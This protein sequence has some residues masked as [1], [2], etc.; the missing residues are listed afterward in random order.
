MWAT[1]SKRIPAILVLLILVSLPGAQAP[2]AETDPPQS[3]PATPA[4][5]V[6]GPGDQI[7]IRALDLEEI[8]DKPFRIGANGTI[9][10]PLLGRVQAAGLTVQELEGQIT[11]SLKPYVRH[12]DVT[13]AVAESPSQSV[14]V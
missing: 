12:P 11:A 6:L 4:D 14:S 3:L 9:N 7:I 5:P 13:V 8:S 2:A 10:L 1:F